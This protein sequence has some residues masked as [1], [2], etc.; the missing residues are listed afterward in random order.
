MAIREGRW[1]CP[2]CETKGLLGRD[3][4]CN[5]CGAPRPEGVRFY[6]PKDAVEVEDP[7]QIAVAKAGADW[8][9]EYCGASNRTT[10]TQCVECGAPRS[11]VT[12]AVRDYRLDEVPRS[13]DRRSSQPIS[14]S[15]PSVSPVQSSL[16]ARK[17]GAIGIC[18]AIV[19]GIG[20]F[21]F[22]PI[23]MDA[24]VSSLSWERTVKIEKLTT[25]TES[26]WSVPTGGRTLSQQEEIRRYEQVL[27]RY[28]TRTRNVSERVQVGTETYVCG[29]RDL[30]NGF[31]ED[32]TCTRAVYETRSRTETYEE[33]IYRDEPVYD[34]KYTYEIDEWLPN[35]EELAAGEGKSARWPEFTLGT[36][37]REAKR[38][39]KY[40]ARFLGERGKIYTLKLDEN[41]WDELEI[42]ESRKLKVNRLGSASLNSDP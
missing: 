1:D 42:G 27:D 35:R 13:G 26:D 32:K 40:Q 29:T 39:E 21:L 11:Q 6:L 23:A 2:S 4:E 22:Q 15:S 30:G 8:I 5:Q 36:D 10:Q 12:Q 38:T 17:L 3:R 16:S 37:E 33:P 28:E 24:T 18:L 7:E 20:I 31:F 9:C 14:V 34:T 19:I 25:V 41:I